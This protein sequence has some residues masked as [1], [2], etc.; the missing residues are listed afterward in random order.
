M[1][2][3]GH[4]FENPMLML[5][6]DLESHYVNTLFQVN[7]LLSG[8]NQVVASKWILKANPSQKHLHYIWNKMSLHM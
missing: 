2:K 7:P 4:P 5:T 1:Q 6:G 8:S 3:L